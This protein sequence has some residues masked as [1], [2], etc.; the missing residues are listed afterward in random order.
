MPCSPRLPTQRKELLASSL[1]IS[2][3]NLQKKCTEK[4][5]TMFSVPYDF[6]L[7]SNWY[8]VGLFDKSKE[9]NHYL[10]YQ[11]Y[12]KT[13]NMFVKSKANDQV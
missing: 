1:M 4:I 7:F 5:S 12:N 8:A 9:C 11:M 2:A 3:R 13:D 6:N 10:Y